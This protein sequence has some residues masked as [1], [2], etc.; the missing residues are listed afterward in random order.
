MRLGLVH[1]NVVG[2]LRQRR[3][4]LRLIGKGHGLVVVLMGILAGN[5][6]SASARRASAAASVGTGAAETSAAVG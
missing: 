2:V 3:I 5:L 1:L 4:V 6:G